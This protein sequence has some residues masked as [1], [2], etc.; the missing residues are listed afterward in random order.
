MAK[1]WMP[2]R[3]MKKDIES[4]KGSGRVWVEKQNC[5]PNSNTFSETR[6]YS[7]QT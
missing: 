1:L 6:E 2:S 3:R 5:E 7:S 4:T